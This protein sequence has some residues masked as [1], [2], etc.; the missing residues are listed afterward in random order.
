[1]VAWLGDKAE[2]VCE[3]S[4]KLHTGTLDF[5]AA[6]ESFELLRTEATTVRHHRT[7]LMSASICG[8]RQNAL[9]YVQFYQKVIYVDHFN[10]R[11]S[12]L[13]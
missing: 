6:L 7:S 12:V 5:D 4:K 10:E 3:V 9:V 2:R 1:M 11:N 8:R 13:K